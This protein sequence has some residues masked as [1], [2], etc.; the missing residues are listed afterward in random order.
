MKLLRRH[1][2]LC[3]T[4]CVLAGG[5]IFAAC[6]K[7]KSKSNASDDPAVAVYPLGL[8]ISVY[9]QTNSTSLSADDDKEQSIKAKNED[10]EKRLKGEGEC[11]PVALAK[12]GPSDTTETCY[13]FD[14][15][16]ILVRRD[17]DS[18]FMSGTSDGKS[19]IS[20][21]TEACMVSFTRGK[22]KQLS[23]MVDRTLGMVQMM[24]CHAKKTGSAGIPGSEGETID[25]KSI[26]E[27]AA[28]AAGK[29]PSHMPVSAAKITKSG[30]KYVTEIEM[31]MP[32]QPGTNPG[33]NDP[34]E[35]IT[36][37]H[38]PGADATNYSGQ[39]VI[40]RDKDFGSQSGSKERIL[41]IN[42]ERTGDSVKYKLLTAAISTKLSANA[43]A[44]G[45]L[46]LNVGTNASGQY[47]DPD[48]NS[49]FSNQNDA[50]SGIMMVGYSMNLTN[51]SG[52]FAYWVNPGATYSERPRGF[53]SNV[54]TDANSG[55]VS[56]CASSGAFS[57]GSIRKSIKESLTITPDGSYHPFACE[58]S[59]TLTSGYYV[60]SRGGVNIRMY[61]PSTSNGTNADNWTKKQVTS[62]ATA[63][64]A[65]QCFTQGSDGV[66]SIDTTKTPDTAGFGLFG[67]ND[68]SLP[69]PPDLGSIK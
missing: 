47:V 52:N 69:T 27:A 39:I 56:G 9:P 2:L 5:L 63:L 48:T 23:S 6:G 21:S 49:V 57:E 67:K 55:L 43:I 14:S 18:A 34:K 3:L 64:V 17:S 12:S 32:A 53:V 45:V 35:K 44:D 13:E 15:D 20:G 31:K 29:D 4:G 66:Y 62:G 33:A 65:R 28:V 41:T 38:N 16:M 10:A 61:V 37:T 22:I 68:S 40:R 36:L 11:F 30:T 60:S 50:A 24:I 19:K 26:M 51:G 46:N 1:H 42:Y 7:K 59:C 8:A 58:S 25:F 54:T